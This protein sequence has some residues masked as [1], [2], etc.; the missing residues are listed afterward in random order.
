MSALRKKPWRIWLLPLLMMAAGVWNARADTIHV[1]PNSTKP[2]KPYASPQTAALDIA[3]ALE[4]AKSGDTIILAAGSTY[5]I[6]NEIIVK[7]GVTLRG[8]GAQKPIIDAQGKCRCVSLRQGASLIGVTVTRGEAREGGGIHCGPGT[9]V[10]EC[11]IVKNTAKNYGGGICTRMR[12]KNPPPCLIRD[13]KIIE[14]QVT[15]FLHTDTP[16]GGGG[17]YAD[18]NTTVRHCLI[19]ANEAAQRGGGIWCHLSGSLAENCTLVKNRAKGQ[20]ARN[21]NGTGSME[22]GG[23]G[24]YCDFGGM[25]RSCLVIANK[26]DKIGGGAVLSTGG[27]ARNCTFVNNST[28][29]SGG[30]VQTLGVAGLVNSIA[31]SNTR[32][33][34]SE[35]DDV[36]VSH[37]YHVDIHQLTLGKANLKHCCIGKLGLHF[38][39]QT[40]Y[41]G[42]TAKY[43][44]AL[45]K[46]T[47]NDF[48][49]IEAD[50]QFIDEKNGDHRLKPTSPCI[51]AA[52]NEE[53]MEKAFDLDRRPRIQDG[54]ADIGAF[55][56][57]PSK[58]VDDSRR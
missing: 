15:G 32:G 18:T 31:W 42:R 52:A 26:A 5:R 17:I 30:G 4:A 16:L 48:K 28:G 2:Q 51:N 3:A 44:P 21:P 40:F 54:T 47:A 7:E 34:K 14:N 8:A 39:K 29:V 1:D 50:P 35:P 9:T 46:N 19:E 12:G 43:N 55:E 53:W 41:L 22:E 25:L 45:Y 37:Y 38:T 11:V 24:A 13:C 57:A 20:R 33:D 49:C 6:D 23:G 56:H 58:K 27:N 10:A 36:Y